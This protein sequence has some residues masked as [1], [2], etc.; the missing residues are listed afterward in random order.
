M[1][2]AVETSE[3]G[4]VY[5]APPELVLVLAPPGGGLTAPSSSGE[6]YAVPAAST[7]TAQTEASPTALADV[8]LLHM[9]GPA[10]AV[11]DMSREYSIAGAGHTAKKLCSP[12]RKDSFRK[13]SPFQEG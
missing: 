5:C 12:L 4:V 6:P 10:A 2:N 8:D 3:S 13:S 9:I 7:I 11:L 1:V